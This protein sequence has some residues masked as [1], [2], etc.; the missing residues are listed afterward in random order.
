LKK[1]KVKFWSFY[2]DKEINE[3]VEFEKYGMDAKI[4]KPV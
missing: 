2:N 1:K 4:I 3:D